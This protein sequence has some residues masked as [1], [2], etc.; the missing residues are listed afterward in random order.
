MS[1]LTLGALKE[2]ADFVVSGELLTAISGGTENAC[3]D[4]GS[5]RPSAEDVR[6]G[7]RTHPADGTYVE[8]PR[9]VK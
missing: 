3:H 1:K 9:R 4:G 8:K 7:P 5:R 6:E 2:R